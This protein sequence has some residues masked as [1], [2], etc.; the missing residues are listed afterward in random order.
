MND[1]EK[2]LCKYVSIAFLNKAKQ[3]Q[4]GIAGCGGIGSNCAHNLVRCGFKNFLLVDHD[5]I[6]A[7]NLNRQFFFLNQTDHPKVDML[8]QNLLAINPDLN[9]KAVQKKITEKCMESLFQ[10]CHVIVEAFDDVIYKKMLTEKYLHS[11]KLVVA[12][13]GIAG[14]GDSDEIVIRK[15]N[16]TFYM[17]GDFK[18]EISDNVHP[19]SPKINIAAA[20]QADI[21]FNYYKEFL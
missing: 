8:K 13:S 1:F 10:S 19:Y 2:G 3:I 21:I 5:V 11:N 20:K 14:S 6:E 16:K 15:L 18:S 7:S 17:V 4:I 9:I 12:V